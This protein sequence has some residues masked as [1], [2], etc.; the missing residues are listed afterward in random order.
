MVV[1]VIAGAIITIGLPTMQGVLAKRQVGIAR[2]ALVVSAARARAEAIQR[3]EV[4]RWK[5]RT[6]AD[7][8]LTYTSNDTLDIMD[9]AGT[10]LR[11]DLW[12]PYDGDMTLCFTPRGF[13]HP[14]CGDADRLPL[15]LGFT[16]GNDTVRLT[17]TA[18]GQ[19]KRN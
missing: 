15:E 17:V 11:A 10:E 3:G 8:V 14:S 12:L 18:L 7:T 5:I 4:V 9:Y 16:L 13:A 2:D 1:L 19:V 6:D